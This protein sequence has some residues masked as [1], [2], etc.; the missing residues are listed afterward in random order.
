MPPAPKRRFDAVVC[1]I[2]GCLCPETTD[3]F[4]GPGLLR[5]A[6]HNRLAREQEDRPPL[7]VCSGRPEPFVEAMSR[8]LGNRLPCVAENGVWL[9]H[10]VGNRY[11]MDPGIGPEHLRAVQGARAWV[12]E[13]LG[14]RGVVMQPGKA[15]SVSLYHT[16]TGLL[17]SLEPVVKEEFERRGWP[18]RLSM[19]WFYINCDLSIVSKA[20]GLDRFMAATGLTRERMAGIGDTMGDLA[21]R[22]RVAFFG[23]PANADERVKAHADYV[24]PRAEVGGVL[25]ILSRL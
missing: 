9:W 19:T 7:T 14:P 5:I 25:D 6:E 20:T 24:S 12:A 21:I 11:D 18:F 23:C 4:D 22:E 17:R 10:P 15:G 2:D 8:L 3:D 16:D 1:D 13:V